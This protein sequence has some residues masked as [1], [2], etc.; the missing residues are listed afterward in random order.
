MNKQ[1]TYLKLLETIKLTQD[2][3]LIINN[4]LNGKK[5][6]VLTISPDFD[7][8]IN[9]FNYDT[10]IIKYSQMIRTI[11]DFNLNEIYLPYICNN[12]YSNNLHK[13]VAKYKELNSCCIFEESFHYIYIDTNRSLHNLLKLNLD[14]QTHKL[15]IKKTEQKDFFFDSYYKILNYI[16]E[17]TE[18]YKADNITDKR[19]YILNFDLKKKRFSFKQVDPNNFKDYDSLFLLENRNKIKDYLIF[20][21]DGSIDIQN[22]IHKIDLFNKMQNF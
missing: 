12:D 14:T 13:Y 18:T 6:A 15:P 10:C 9:Q 2:K 7:N 3:E 19:P 8:K 20:N 16:K 4:I 21:T 1:D 17:T 22:T 11:P 5:Y